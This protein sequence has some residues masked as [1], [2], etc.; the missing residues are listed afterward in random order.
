MVADL[1]GGLFGIE[2]QAPA[3]GSADLPVGKVSVDTVNNCEAGTSG[4][5]AGPHSPEAQEQYSQ[6]RNCM[7]RGNKQAESPDQIVQAA[8]EEKA[9]E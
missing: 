1:V 2:P 8:A 5:K 4:Q 7:N 9:G 3:S 6:L